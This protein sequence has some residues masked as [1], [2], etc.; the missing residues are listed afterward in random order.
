MFCEELIG[1]A[2]GKVEV[3]VVFSAVVEEAVALIGIGDNRAIVPGGERSIA[4]DF[5]PV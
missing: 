4:I 5:S 2:H 3:M 1:F